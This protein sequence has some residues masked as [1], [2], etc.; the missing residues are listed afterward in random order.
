MCRSFTITHHPSTWPPLTNIHTEKFYGSHVGPDG[1]NTALHT[2]C[3]YCSILGFTKA[4]RAGQKK[5]LFTR[6]RHSDS[7]PFI[8]G[9]GKWHG[10][11]GLDGLVHHLVVA[12]VH[13]VPELGLLGNHGALPAVPP[14]LKKHPTGG[15]T[16]GCIACAN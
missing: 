14:A 13:Q 12:G 5:I 16:C 15:V 8:F 9:D 10:G 3:W 7:L 2:H 1:F 11:G 4:V 6:R